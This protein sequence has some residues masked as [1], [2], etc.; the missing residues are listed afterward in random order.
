MTALLKSVPNRKQI[1]DKTG[2]D[3]CTNYIYELT[4]I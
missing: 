3:V 2:V 1:S 4:F